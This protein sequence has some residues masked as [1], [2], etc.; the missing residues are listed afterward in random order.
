VEQAFTI[1]RPSMAV[2]GEGKWEATDRFAVTLGLRYTRDEVEYSRSRAVIKDLGGNDRASLVPYSNPFNAGL[3]AL[4]QSETTEEF[5]GRII[6]DF[7][8]TDSVLTYAGYSRGYRA[9]TYN[10]LAYQSVEQVYF[11]E[12]E[13][14]DAFELGIKSRFWDDRI[15][16]N[17]A[18]FHYDYQNQQIAEIIGATSFLRNA[19]GEVTG[20]EAELTVQATP[21]LRIDASIGWL[22]TR[23]DDNQRF[24]EGGL[25]IGGNEFPNAPNV[26]GSLGFDWTMWGNGDRGISLR[27]DMQYMGSYWFDPYNDYGQS[28]S[29]LN[30]RLASVQLAR[31]NPSYQLYNARLTYE[32][33]RFSVSA[34]GKNLTNEFYWSY[35]L[36]LNAFYLD[37]FARG[38]PRMYGLEATVKF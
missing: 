32:T 23:Y 22:D 19:N 27:G 34:W 17:A 28:P 37:Y 16:L 1:E 5:T 21:R 25:D 33:E 15:Q 3:A 10:A 36:N 30:A 4:A 35:G 2:Y 8:L 13:Q 12:P 20:A 24:Y 7:K 11:V 26:S 6:V 14:V 31:G 9:G 29:Q 18:A 38:A